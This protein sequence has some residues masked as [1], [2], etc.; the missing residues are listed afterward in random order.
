MTPL[1]LSALWLKVTL[2]SVIAECVLSWLCTYRLPG[3]RPV[4]TYSAASMSIPFA[5]RTSAPG[6][7]SGGFLLLRGKL[8]PLRLQRM[9]VQSPA[10][11]KDD[12]GGHVLSAQPSIAARNSSPGL[13]EAPNHPCRAL[14]SGLWTDTLQRTKRVMHYYWLATRQ[15]KHGPRRSASFSLVFIVLP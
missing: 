14:D 6:L 13:D 10:T 8:K 12:Q 11:G 3:R 7:R 15:P 2:H 9:S 5:W 4:S 1:H